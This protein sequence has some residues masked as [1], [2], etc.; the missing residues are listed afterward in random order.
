MENRKNS[1]TLE[2]L[3]ASCIGIVFLTG[4]ATYVLMLKARYASSTAYSR[5]QMKELNTESFEYMIVKHFYSR[6]ELNSL[7]NPDVSA[8]ENQEETI[9]ASDD[10]E[11][12]KIYGP[13]YEGYMMLVHNPADLSV[14]INPYFAEG[15]AGPSLDEYVSYYNAIGGLNAGGF[16]DVNGKGDGSLASGIVIHDGKLIS[17]EL[18]AYWPMICIT[19]TNRLTVMYATGQQMLDWGVRDA[20]TFQPFLISEGQVVYQ[21]GDGNYPNLSPRSAIGQ[22]DDGT[23]LLLAIDGRGPSSFG[24][25]Y[26]DL[27][28]IFQSYG[29]VTAA[30]LDG[31]NS[32]AMMYNGS[33][34]NTPVSMYGSRNLPTVFL[35]RAEGN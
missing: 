35:I 23:F 15:G 22:T 18:D 27:I 21:S 32:T 5:Q 8:S 7:Q 17:G 10:I 19:Y 2:L 16:E 34:V 30:T 6:E 13:T 28:S 9:T 3:I 26:E 20:V 31:G 24:A 29:A 14:A 33:Y 12:Q 11:I 1:V 25:T 4:I